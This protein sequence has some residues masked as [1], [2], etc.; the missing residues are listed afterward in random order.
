MLENLVSV[1]A[2]S[3]YPISLGLCLSL[4]L[5]YN[6][7]TNRQICSFSWQMRSFSGWMHSFLGWI[8]SFLLR[9]CF[10]S[11]N[12][13]FFLLLDYFHPRNDS[14]VYN[15]TMFTLNWACANSVLGMCRHNWP[16]LWQLWWITMTQTELSQRHT[17]W[18]YCLVSAPQHNSVQDLFSLCLSQRRAEWTL[19]NHSVVLDKSVFVHVISRVFW[20]NIHVYCLQGTPRETPLRKGSNC[21]CTQV[22]SMP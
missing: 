15:A 12:Y 10:W 21:K 13:A 9:D 17:H 18:V 16:S 6:S 8:C 20:D 3:V 2:K 1:S 11:I 14:F 5:S 4:E 22:F 7:I 19:H